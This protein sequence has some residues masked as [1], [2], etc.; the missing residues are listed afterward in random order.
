MQHKTAS[1]ESLSASGT[2]VKTNVTPLLS[3]SYWIFLFF[4]SWPMNCHQCTCHTVSESGPGSGPWSRSNV[5]WPISQPGYQSI[6]VLTSKHIDSGENITCLVDTVLWTE[7]CNKLNCGYIKA[8]FRY[9]QIIKSI[10]KK[11]NNRIYCHNLPESILINKSVRN[12]ET[13]DSLPI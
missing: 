12:E 7:T 3:M 2:F 13:S 1:W 10:N 11:C 8:T 4:L 9:C 5:P 6:Q